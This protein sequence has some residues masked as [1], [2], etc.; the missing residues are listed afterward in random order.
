MKNKSIKK[1][2]VFLALVMAFMITTS[3]VFAL[4]ITVDGDENPVGEWGADPQGCTIGTTGC[5]RLVTD[6]QDVFDQS[7]NPYLY[8]D[9]DDFHVTNDG[10]N[11]Y[12]RVDFLGNG[13]AAQNTFVFTVNSRPI[14]TI[15]M[16]I[17]SSASTG[18]TRPTGNCDGDESMTGVDY[19]MRFI[20]QEFDPDVPSIEFWDCFD[21]SCAQITPTPVSFGYNA[22]ADASMEVGIPLASLGMTGSTCP[23][24]GI[25]PCTF[26]LGGFYDNGIEPTDDSVPNNGFV[27]GTFGD[28]SPTAISLQAFNAVNANN[29][30]VLGLV[31]ILVLGVISF[32]FILSRREKTS[33]I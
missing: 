14:F 31:I 26:R 21:G 18:V 19:F 9:I 32:G 11:F 30:I 24:G 23:G 27:T 29:G 5:S 28:G 25:Q 16:D 13:T 10:T 8:Y 3:V 12:M 4:V 1:V 7:S 17:D 33:V 22:D 20:A 15:C 6:G 2:S